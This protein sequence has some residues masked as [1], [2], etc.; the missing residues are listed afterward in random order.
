[1]FNKKKNYLQSKSLKAKIVKSNFNSSLTKQNNPY[2]RTKKKLTKWFLILELVLVFVLFFNIIIILFK[3]SIFDLK[4]FKISGL[5]RISEIEFRETLNNLLDQSRLCCFKNRNY[6]LF[7]NLETREILKTRF[8]LE[9]IK[10]KKEFP[11][12]LKIYVQE[13]ISSIIYD[14]GQKYVFLDL[15]GNLN[16]NIQ[17]V[18]D[19]EWVLM[20]DPKQPSSTIKIHKPDYNFIFNNLKHKYP[21][22]YDQDYF[23]LNLKLEDR[24]KVISNLIVWFNY[25][26]S[27]YRFDLE[28]FIIKNQF[29]EAEIIVNHGHKI[30]ISLLDSAELQIKNLQQFLL[31]FD[32]SLWQEYIDLRFLDRIYYY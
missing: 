31:N 29:L 30:K 7:N 4:I 32:L 2:K 19:Y 3:H 18:A 16:E 27:N 11:D 14:D 24:K 20:P 9:S 26:V 15:S 10:I 25:L 1:M 21:L 23:L 22:V 8:G 6:F 5:N 28:Y 13:K 17:N 12:Y